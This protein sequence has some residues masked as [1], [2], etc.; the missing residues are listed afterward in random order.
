MIEARESRH[1]LLCAALDAT[2]DVLLYIRLSGEIRSLNQAGRALLRALFPR[3]R[4]IVTIAEAP[5]TLAPILFE[6]IESLHQAS[7]SSPALTGQ[8]ALTLQGRTLRYYARDYTEKG[9]PL[10][11]LLRLVLEVP[12]TPAPA[13]EDGGWRLT[14]R[15]RELVTLLARGRSTT[16]ICTL[17][18]ISRETFKTHLKHVYEKTGAHGRVDLMVRVRKGRPD[19]S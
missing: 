3:R 7:E 8:G 12:R 16:Q 5:L 13:E 15:E 10:G 14:Q 9:R 18:G 19:R 1:R 4:R 17:Q 6:L 11:I 2:P